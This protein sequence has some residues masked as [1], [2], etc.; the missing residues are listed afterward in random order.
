MTK[1]EQKQIV[2]SILNH[3]EEYIYGAINSG[4]IPESWDGI[5]LR[6]YI[7]S[8]IS[9]RGMDKKRKKEYDNTILINGL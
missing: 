2:N 8:Q 6:E 4:K 9:W 3:T 7:S 1:D 5:E